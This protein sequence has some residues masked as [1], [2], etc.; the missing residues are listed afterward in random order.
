MMS[1]LGPKHGMFILLRE[2]VCVHSQDFLLYG[3]LEAEV[4]ATAV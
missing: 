3:P 1:R 2:R 4:D